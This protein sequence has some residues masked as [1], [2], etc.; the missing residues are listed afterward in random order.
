MVM[1]VHFLHSFF[2]EKDILVHLKTHSIMETREKLRLS[3]IFPPHHR[4]YTRLRL[5]ETCNELHHLRGGGANET[6]TP[7]LSSLSA[8]NPGARRDFT[9]VFFSSSFFSSTR[10][11][12]TVEETSGDGYANDP[13]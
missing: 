10:V 1:G 12:H 2:A 5:H 8:V 9:V 3:Q 11:V 6:Q 4:C 7:I 13:L